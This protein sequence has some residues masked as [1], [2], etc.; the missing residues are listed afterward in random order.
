MTD[1]NLEALETVRDALEVNLSLWRDDVEPG[2]FDRD[3]IEPTQRALAALS[4]I[5]ARLGEETPQRLRLQAD[6][7]NEHDTTRMLIARLA[8]AEAALRL[9]ADNGATSVVG[10]IEDMDVWCAQT[11]G[12]LK[13]IARNY[14][15]EEGS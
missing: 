4:H 5:E 15:T 1:T 9:I 3:V 10:E 6:L 7:D 2:D 11:I 12:R 14:F 8:Q 13:D